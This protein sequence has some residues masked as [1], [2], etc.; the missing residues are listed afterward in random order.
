LFID[1]AN[2]H[3][4]ARALGFEIDYKRLLT[5]FQSRGT[6]VRAFYYTAIVEDQEF[7]AIRP[8]IDW[9]NYNGFTVVTKP[10]KEFDDGEGR[11]KLKRNMSVELAIDAMELAEYLDQIV[12]FAGDGDFRPLIEAVQGR[13][14]H[15]TVVSTVESRPPMVA[16]ELR[17][18]ADVFIDLMELRP[19][20]SREPDHR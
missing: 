10:A 12:L 5:E 13:G 3:A 9:L 4:T 11:R 20:I 16:D 17:R 6:L 18:Q 14:V 8:L 7:S 2:I 1:G 15:V 19:K